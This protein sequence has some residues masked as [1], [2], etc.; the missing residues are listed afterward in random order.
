MAVGRGRTN[1]AECEARQESLAVGR[2]RTTGAVMEPLTIVQVTPHSWK[3]RHE[4]NEFVRRSSEELSACGHRVLIAAPAAT[5]KAARGARSAIAA[6]RQRPAALFKGDGPRLLEVGGRVALPRG[7]RPRPAPIAVDA[8][9]DLEVLLG[10]VPIDI[11]HV[12]EPFAPSLLLDGAAPFELAER[13]H[14][15]RALRTSALHPGRAALGGD[16]LRA[17]RRTHRYLLPDRRALGALLPR[18]LRADPP[19]RRREATAQRPPEWTAADPL[20]PRG[21][22]GGAAAVS[23]CPAAPSAGS[24]LGGDGADAISLRHPAPHRPPP[25]GADPPRRPG[26]GAAGGP[27][28]GRRRTLRRL[29]WAGPC[30]AVGSAWHWR[31]ARSQSYRGCRCIRSCS[32]TGRWG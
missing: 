2:A 11:V 7:P 5:R 21:G 22:A 23:A 14:F 32:A 8:S 30:A 15:P 13:R 28:R 20:L 16:L 24:R 9:R 12:H 1:W 31:A 4:V 29:R 3:T 17:P 19:R 18:L 26:G 25:A 6:A 10:S 27:D